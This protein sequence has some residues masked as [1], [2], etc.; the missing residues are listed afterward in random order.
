MSNFVQEDAINYRPYPF[1]VCQSNPCAS[2]ICYRHKLWNGRCG[3][4][5]YEIEQHHQKLRVCSYCLKDLTDVQCVK[6]LIEVLDDNILD[7]FAEYDARWTLQ[8]ARQYTN[9]DESR[10]LESWCSCLR[11]RA[12]YIFGTACDC[13]NVVCYA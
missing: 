1:G 6:L 4:A 5:V 2:P 11:C 3:P 8:L 13:P 10:T 7:V 12:S 9:L